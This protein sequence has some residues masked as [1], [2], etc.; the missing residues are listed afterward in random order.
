M[1][2]RGEIT[3]R[4]IAVLIETIADTS[5]MTSADMIKT[6]IGMKTAIAYI[7]TKIVTVI[8]TMTLFRCD[9]RASAAEGITPAK[10]SG[11]VAFRR[12]TRADLTE[13]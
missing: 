7:A 1:S 4:M 13:L 11:V 12:R 5:L 6:A 3:T 9:D 8:V 10:A 2:K